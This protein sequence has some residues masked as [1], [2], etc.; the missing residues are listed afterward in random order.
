MVTR[1]EKKLGW[2]GGGKSAERAEGEGSSVESRLSALEKGH[3]AIMKKL[4]VIERVASE[5][6]DDTRNVEHKEL[7][8]NEGEEEKELKEAKRS[9]EEKEPKEAKRSEDEKIVEMK[10][11]LE[12]MKRCQEETLK[13][14]KRNFDALTAQRT[15][16]VP[17][18]GEKRRLGDSGFMYGGQRY[19]G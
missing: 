16:I 7:K 9:E 15:Q 18:A 2:F 6:R 13:E 8:R 19:N 4:E 11:E 1:V 12:E 3:E 10:R 17:P 5:A 14:M